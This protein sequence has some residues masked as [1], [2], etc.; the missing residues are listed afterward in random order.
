MLLV[1]KKCLQLQMTTKYFF[2]LTFYDLGF[3]GCIEFYLP[4]Y[5]SDELNMN[6]S[7]GQEG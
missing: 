1:I 6:E 2:L 4:I 5:P 3:E 7:S